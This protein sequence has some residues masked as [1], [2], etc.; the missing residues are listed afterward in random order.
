MARSAP[1]NCLSNQKFEPYSGAAT[2]RNLFQRTIEF[3][4]KT[5]DSLRKCAQ[6][7]KIEL[8]S[9]IRII[10]EARTSKK[11]P[12]WA[13]ICP[14]FDT[15]LGAWECTFFSLLSRNA[16]RAQGMP[17]RVPRVCRSVQKRHKKQTKGRH[18]GVRSHVGK[19]VFYYSKT[20][21]LR[22]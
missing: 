19:C 17:S 6:N 22:V 2:A 12:K 3:G 4:R 20:L 11:P 9:L 16:F 21:L 10:V 1:E 15:F 14:H 18:G 5:S 8:F 7:V 13:Q